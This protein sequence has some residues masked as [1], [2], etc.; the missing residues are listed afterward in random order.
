MKAILTEI[1]R[2]RTLMGLP[3]ITEGVGIS[4]ILDA[5]VTG[6]E[7]AVMKKITKE[8]V[9]KFPNNFTFGSAGARTTFINKGLSSLQT[10]LQKI[11]RK[12]ALA[13][14][15]QIDN[16]QIAKLASFIMKNE[17]GLVDTVKDLV[18]KGVPVKDIKGKLGTLTDIP[19]SV[20]NTMIKSIEVDV[21]FT[22]ERIKALAKALEASVGKNLKK[23]TD[24]AINAFRASNPGATEQQIAEYMVKNLPD[25]FF[26]AKNVE[27]LIKK[28]GSG[29]KSILQV[30]LMN[31]DRSGPAWWKIIG[32]LGASTTIAMV[33]A[34]KSYLEREY[35][36]DAIDVLE[37]DPR[38][39]CYAGYITPGKDK[40]HFVVL[41]PD[42]T[43]AI[44]KFDNKRFW[45]VDR[46]DKPIK[47]L[48]CKG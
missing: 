19:D 9:D 17:D 7:S 1:N 40:D 18:Q 20:I 10:A 28:V 16:S 46:N 29:F 44:I 43:R 21:L 32:L 5:A 30:L 47:E 37:K 48:L 26:S 4:G 27:I 11:S 36:P 22:P 2:N 14:I 45:Y 35:I 12:E 15:V 3:L 31:K 39:N 23:I 24:E 42:N 34:F 25:N 13:I 8:I 6:M 33:T 38:Y 41:E